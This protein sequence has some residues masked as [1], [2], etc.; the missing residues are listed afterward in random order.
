MLGVPQDQLSA[1]LRRPVPE[2][3]ALVLAPPLV[4]VAV[5]FSRLRSQWRTASV[6]T[7]GIVFT[8]LDYSALEPTMRMLDMEF[9]NKPRAFEQ[10][11]TMEM[12]AV[13]AMNERD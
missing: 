12:E 7:A 6:G 1:E 5:L 10:L 13:R 4:D 11:R 8:G 3:D 2:T 9:P